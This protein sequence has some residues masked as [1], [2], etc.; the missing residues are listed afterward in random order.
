MD[1]IAQLRELAIPGTHKRVLAVVERHV[2]PAPDLS[3]LDLGAGQ[4]AMSQRLLE[5]GYRV[6]ACDM[7]PEMFLCPGVECRQSDIH[8]P[9]P[10]D[11]DQFDMVLAVEVVEHLESQLGL[12]EE[13]A[14]ILKPGGAFI[15]TTP[16]IASLK[17]RAS[18]LLTGYFYSHGPLDPEVNDPVSQHIAAFTPNRYRFLLARAG[19]EMTALEADRYQKSSLWLSWLTPLI[20]FFARR[21]HGEDVGVAVANC[22]AALYARSMIGISRKRAA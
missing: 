21:K 4:G 19:L 7:F 17:S 20:R 6:S 22:P 3:V 12:F 13:V 1:D 16:N 10:Y 18:F 11:D 8:Q 5:A 9:L 15:F 14:R 2:P